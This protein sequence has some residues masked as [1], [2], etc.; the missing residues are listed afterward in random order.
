M[1]ALLTL[2]A[3]VWVVFGPIWALVAL[4]LILLIG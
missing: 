4:L 3:L 2:V 1:I